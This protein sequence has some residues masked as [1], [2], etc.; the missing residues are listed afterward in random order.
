LQRQL[1]H[2]ELLL[3]LKPNQPLAQTGAAYKRP[4]TQAL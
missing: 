4:V 1:S 2:G 3:N